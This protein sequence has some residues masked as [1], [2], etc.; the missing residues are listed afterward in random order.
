[1]LA[2]MCLDI[3]EKDKAYLGELLNSLGNGYGGLYTAAEALTNGKPI[4]LRQNPP[5][6]N[7]I[8]DRYIP[9]V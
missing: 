6:G 5:Q 8:L 7:L 2:L 3:K 1:M 9:R 4:K